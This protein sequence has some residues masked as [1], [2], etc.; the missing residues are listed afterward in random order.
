ML[1]H[2]WNVNGLRAVLGKGFAEILR[3]SGADVYCLQETK[4]NPDQVD[5]SFLDGT[6][7]QAHW[8]SADKKGYAGTAVL[9]RLAPL[10]VA[11]G[12]GGPAHD[13]EGRVLTLEFPAFFLVNVYTP[14]S[15]DQLRRLP[16]RME[17]DR[18]F[19][20]YVKG[21]EGRGKPVA[22][23]GDLNVA[24]QEI[25]IARPKENRRSAGFTDEERAGFTDLLAAGFVDTFREFEKGPGHY[26]WW[27]F[28]GGARAR[29]IGWRID[30]F[31]VSAALRPQLRAAGIHPD[32]VGSDHCP[33]WVDLA[34]A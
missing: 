1:L 4:A 5:L 21:L 3:A 19:R 25:D 27:S 16:Y 31:V 13:G 30:Y 28:R 2:S 9:T 22:L 10:A 18:A 20:A 24:H 11:R 8:H 29:N 33:V 34:F 6:G 14:N 7:Y 32:I 17:W 15:Q 12:M 26:T 23:C